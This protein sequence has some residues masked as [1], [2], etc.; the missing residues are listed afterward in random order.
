MGHGRGV[1]EFMAT[2]AG[3]SDNAIID[4][5]R[6]H[7]SD[8]NGWASLGAAVGGGQ[9]AGTQAYESGMRV[10]AQTADA[11]AQAKDRIQKSNAAQQAAQAMR[12]PAL[13]S[14]LGLTP[15]LGNYYAT[16]AEQG[17]NAEAITKSMLDVVKAKNMR[18]IAD[19]TQ[20]LEARHDAAFS[21]A[22][23]S[24]APHAEGP[25]GSVFDPGANAGS[26]A[27]TVSPLQ[28]QV[29]QAGVG[30]KQAQAA[31]APVNAAAHTTSADAAA[32][33]A[34]NN[35]GKLK[36]GYQFVQDTDKTSP[37]YGQVKTNPDGTP[38]QQPNPN[39]GGGREGAVNA[40]YNQ[41][42][43]GA[44]S[45]MSRELQNV[46][47]IGPTTSAGATGFAPGH[48]GIVATLSDNL[49]RALSD[50]DQQ[51][52]HKSMQNMG[53]FVGILENGGR[54]TTKGASGSAQEA[55][56]S[57]A[58]DT[59]NSRLYG[60]AIARQVMEAQQDRIHASGTTPQ[61]ID[62][63]DSEVAKAKK[64]IPFTPLDVINFGRSGKGVAFADWLKQHGSDNQAAAPTGGAPAGAAPAT[65][66]PPPGFKPVN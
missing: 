8:P 7:G 17:G 55:I 2:D 5:T 51:E 19:P 49:G 10:G 12:D 29:A 34:N 53:R 61:V 50:T 27:T 58:A 16:Q 44:A 4:S 56:E 45:G 40:R 15:E 39:A 3:I 14:Q 63:Y 28:T 33:N 42:M 57:Q 64:A 48:T 23:A 52:F 18:T 54:A 25:L 9:I 41:N 11:L 59:Q 13:Q 6:H 22:P 62:A 66:G 47:A 46:A 43:L 31:A 24:M 32:A 36:P 26:G 20:P 21:E 1:E 35:Q 60:L 30:L 38:M 65:G 37:T